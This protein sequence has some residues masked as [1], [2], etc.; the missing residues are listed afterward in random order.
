[1]KQL[2]GT[3]LKRFLRS[4]PPRP[5]LDLVIVCQS[6]GYPVNVG[7][8]FRLADALGAKEVLLTGI[9]PTPPHPTISKVGREKDRC[10]SW[11]FIDRPETALEEL[12]ARGYWIAA[13][14]ISDESVPYYAMDYPQ[15]VALVLGNEDHGVTRSC[16]A[17][18]H[19]AVF[20]PM[21]GKGKSLNVH[22]ALAV[23]GYHMLFRAMPEPSQEEGL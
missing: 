21:Y 23:V 18:C 6:V 9:T 16:L 20:V 19:A 4:L 7:S 10:V 12:Q 11:R 1:M 17:L 14:E 5:A 8:V 2:R 3:P 13:L 15:K 22:I